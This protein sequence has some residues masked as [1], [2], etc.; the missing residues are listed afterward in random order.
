[1]ITVRRADYRSETDANNIVMLLD[2]YARDPM[3]GEQPLSRYTRE[4]L[5]TE[6]AKRDGIS[7][8]AYC[9]VTPVG[10]LNG[11]EGFSTFACKPLVNIHD[12]AVLAEY[13]GRGIGLV[14][15]QALEEIARQSDCCKLTLEVLPGNAVAAR[16]YQKFGFSGYELKPAMGQALFWEKPLS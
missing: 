14:L 11:F 6:L 2:A 1:M 12:I 7:L 4:N 5:V 3:G 15:L 13:R 10:L 9:G 16:V 8:L